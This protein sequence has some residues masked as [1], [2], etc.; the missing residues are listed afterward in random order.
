MPD[1]SRHGPLTPS[2]DAD[3]IVH[4]VFDLPGSTVNKLNGDVLE[5]LDALITSWVATPP[6]AIVFASARD[7]FCVGA[8][9][10]LIAALPDADAAREGSR[11][12]QELFNRLADLDCPTVAAIRGSCL[13]GGLEWALACDRIVV[14]DA[15]GTRLGLPEVRLGL[16]PAWGGTQRLPARIGLGPAV[17]MMAT[18]RRLSADAA[19]AKGLADVRAP[20]AQLQAAATAVAR[21]LIAARRRAGRVPRAT[22][23]GW[24]GWLA[25]RLPPARALIF[26]QVRRTIHR[27]AGTHYPAPGAIVE[28]VAASFLTPAARGLARERQLFAELATG[29]IS[30]RLVGLFQLTQESSDWYDEEKQATGT[31]VETVAILGAGVMGAGIARLCAEHEISV[32]LRDISKEALEAGTGHIRSALARRVARHRLTASEKDAILGRLTPT[33]RVEDLAPADLIIEAVVEK[34]DLKKAVL[35]EAERAAPSAVLASNT[36]ALS[37]TAMSAAL[38]RPQRLGGLHFFNPVDRMPLV[39]VVAGRRTALQTTGALLAL[40]RRLGKT[41]VR[42]ADSPGFLVNRLLSVYLGEALML[43]EEG[44]DVACLDR[45]LRDFGMPVGPLELLDQIGLDIAGEVV[46]SL[47]D[48]FGNRQATTDLVAR[49]RAEGCLGV[50]TGSGFYRHHGKKPEVNRE[51]LERLTGRPGTGPLPDDVCSILLYPMV[52]E[53]ARCLEESVVQRPGEVDLAMVMGIGW[54]PFT[55][56]LLRWADE[57]GLDG[58]IRC[59]TSLA[60]LR[61]PRFAPPACLAAREQADGRFHPG[62]AAA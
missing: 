58:I 37:I 46:E 16:L 34:L 4:V 28:A 36:S 19:M 25:R 21:D 6:A 18:G 62:S 15:P 24:V 41:P 7:H 8:D 29:P 61:G 27:R 13:G 30:R 39:E 35:A 38:K 59:L 11:R 23:Q 55:G 44:V 60:A 14:S 48:L 53:A 56:G 40:V 1:A 5:A 54:P 32:R 43:V 42:V 2:S 33:T 10:G 49:L 51:V 57:Q 20:D 47:R 9:I 12:G 17:E 45:A 22:R 52:A 3:G 31:P 50:K 26:S